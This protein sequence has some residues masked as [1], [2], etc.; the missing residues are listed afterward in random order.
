MRYWLDS[1]AAAGSVDR[2]E[3]NEWHKLAK[4]ATEFDI[5]LPVKQATGADSVTVSLNYYYCQEGENGVCKTGSVVW[6]IPLELTADGS[7]KPLPIHLT[8]K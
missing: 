8:V 4:P 7:S 6:K 3:L 5:R 1:E 2:A